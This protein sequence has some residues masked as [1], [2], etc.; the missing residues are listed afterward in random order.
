MTENYIRLGLRL[1]RHIDGLVDA[2]YG[3]AELQQEVD[4]EPLR[5]PATLVADAGRLLD[6]TDGWLRHQ[7]V[8]LETIARKLAGEQIAYADEV[9]RCYGIRPQRTPEAEFEQAH[10]DLARV[11]PGDGSLGER[12]QAW[13]EENPVPGDQLP[14]VLESLTA[15]LR[16]RTLELFG[17]PKGEK[18]ELDYVTDE[19]WSAFNYYLGGLRSRVAVNLDVPMVPNF[20]TELMAHELYPGHHT[21]HA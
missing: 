5:E 3:P 19:P 9:E 20:V 1:G 6:V 12:Y 15:E 8:G 4:A 17:L 10:A 2:Y 11:L 18:A 14:S 13:R 21:E 7:V 16:R